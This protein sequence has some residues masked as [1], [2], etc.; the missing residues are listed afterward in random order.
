M[1]KKAWWDKGFKPPPPPYKHYWLVCEMC[2]PAV[3]C[4]KCGNNCCNAMYGE[5]PDGSKCDLCPSAYKKQE[6]EYQEHENDV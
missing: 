2:G 4:G 3:I 1:K 5:M 6:K